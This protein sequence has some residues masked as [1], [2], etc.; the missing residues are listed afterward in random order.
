MLEIG[1]ENFDLTNKTLRETFDSG[2][3]DKF[4]YNDLLNKTQFKLCKLICNKCTGS[5][6]NDNK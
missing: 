2:I 4:V 6:I 3:L 5:G 1:F